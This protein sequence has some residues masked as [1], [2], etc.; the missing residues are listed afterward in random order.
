MATYGAEFK[1]ANGETV[2]DHTTQVLAVT[3]APY[4]AYCRDYSMN[5][6]N[7]PYNGWWSDWEFVKFTDAQTGDTTGLGY[8]TW[9]VLYKKSPVAH[10]QVWYRPDD[11]SHAV[12]TQNIFCVSSVGNGCH[13]IFTSRQSPNKT[14][15]FMDVYTES[16]V[17]AW[18]AASLIKSPVILQVFTYYGG[19]SP[20]VIDLA[21]YNLPINELYLNTSN[22]GEWLDEEGALIG[23][24]CVK[25]VGNLI[26]CNI[27]NTTKLVSTVPIVILLA[28]ILPF[29]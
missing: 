3:G 11:N 25:R 22:L 1:A 19:T 12:I 9:Q 16:G 7:N 29:T 23:G 18:S 28:R 26:Y 2:L 10:E 21:A 13:V 15:G 24:L 20:L 27:T 5:D 8:I 4:Y 6:V 14:E 17:L